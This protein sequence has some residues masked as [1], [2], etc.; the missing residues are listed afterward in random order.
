MEWNPS[1]TR[2]DE[3]ERMTFKF[4]S[5]IQKNSLSRK[6]HLYTHAQPA[7]KKNSSET[8]SLSVHHLPFVVQPDSSALAR[9]FFVSIYLMKTNWRSYEKC[10]HS[11]F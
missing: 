5:A 2:D 8:L 3:T 6:N 11:T 4:F 10:G 9:S 1:L 7:E